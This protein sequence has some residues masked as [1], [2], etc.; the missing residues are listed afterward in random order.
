MSHVFWNRWSL[1]FGSCHLTVQGKCSRYL[2]FYKLILTWLEG[3]PQTNASIW[4]H[5]FKEATQNVVLQRWIRL[6][7]LC[8]HQLASTDWEIKITCREFK[9]SSLCG[10]PKKVGRE[11][12]REKNV[13]GYPQSPSLFSQTPSPF[14]P[15][16][17]GYREGC[18]T[19]FGLDTFSI[20]MKLYGTST[21][22]EQG[23]QL[24]L[25]LNYQLW[26][27]YVSSTFIQKVLVLS[28]ECHHGRRK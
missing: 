8:H 14:D 20:K 11:G 21:G 15:Y 24:L 22:L 4:H 7:I 5:N 9:G 6:V 10:R 12:E 3:Q 16:Y 17:T 13:K 27:Q 2:S 28:R 23:G 18:K 26:L 19:S 1:K 25:H